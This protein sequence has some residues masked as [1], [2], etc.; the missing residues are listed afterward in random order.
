[1]TILAG[2]SVSLTIELLQALLPT[3]DSSLAD[4]VTNF[5]GTVIGAGAAVIDKL[6]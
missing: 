2:A 3:R 1:M 6:G 4:V 5:L